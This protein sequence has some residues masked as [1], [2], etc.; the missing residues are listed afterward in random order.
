MSLFWERDERALHET[1][2]KY[3]ALAACFALVFAVTLGAVL[4]YAAAKTPP[5]PTLLHTSWAY[6][7]ENLRGLTQM[8]DL[9]ARIEI[10]EGRAADGSLK[11]IYTATVHTPIYGASPNETIE[12]VFTGVALDHVPWDA[13]LEEVSSYLS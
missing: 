9:I 2:E 10:H 7:Y 8:S 13:F 4:G 1:A 12:L 6:R 3:G 5:A 11:T